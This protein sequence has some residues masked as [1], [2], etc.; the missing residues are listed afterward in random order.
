VDSTPTP[1]RRPLDSADL[2]H[3]WSY[4]ENTGYTCR[5]CG[6][7]PGVP[8]SLPCEVRVAH[9]LATRD[10]ARLAVEQE[11]DA[12]RRML[13]ECTILSGADT[14][15]NTLENGG[16]VHLWRRAV[17]EVRELR[18]MYDALLRDDAQVRQEERAAIVAWLRSD[19]APAAFAMSYGGNEFS[20][21]ADE[22]ERG[23]H[24]PEPR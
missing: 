23:A 15:G 19:H 6:W 4:N 3:D 16:W 18:A 8:Y 7:A 11:R 17:D 12:A 22:I 2:T 24:L 21:A 20:V 13:A 1:A 14:D 10:A 9:A 5:D